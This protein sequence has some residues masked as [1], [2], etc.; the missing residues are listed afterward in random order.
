EFSKRMAQNY[1]LR[2]DISQK[3]F[4]IKFLNNFI[5]QL[6]PLF[7]YSIGGYLVITGSLSFGA[8]VAVLAAYKDLAS[9][10]RE[11]LD[12][13]QS[14]QDTEIKYE[15]IIEQFAP[16]GMISSERQLG[17]PEAKAAEGELAAV[18][19]SWIND[20]GIKIIDGVSLALKPASHIAIVGP[21]TGGKHELGMLLSGIA[22][23]T[24][25]Q[26]CLGGVDLTTLPRAMVARHVG[27][28]GQNTPLF[29]G[30]FFDN[31]VIGLQ[32]RPNADDPDDRDAVARRKVE[33]FEAELTGNSIDNIDADWIDYE[34]AGAS[35]REQLRERILECLRV[36]ELVG[37]LRE[38]GLRGQVDPQKRPEIADVMLKARGALREHLTAPEMRGY[39]EMFDEDRFNDQ[40]SIAENVLFGTPVGGGFDVERLAEH[41]YVQQV[42]DKLRLTDHWTEVGSQIAAQMVE[43]FSGLPPGHELLQRYSFISP[44]ELP[45]YSAALTRMHRQG[46]AGMKPEERARFLSLVFRVVPARHRF[47]VID[48]TL[49]DEVLQARRLFAQDLPAAMAPLVQFFDVDRYNGAVTLYDNMLFGR[50]APGQAQA[51]SRV[52]EMIVDALQRAGM[53][54]KVLNAVIDVGLDYQ[55]GIGGTRL[56][57]AMRQKLAVA[58]ALLKQP[59][60][61][62]LDDPLSVLETSAQGRVVDQV[63]A[64]SKDRSVLWTLQRTQFSKHFARVMVVVDGRIAEQGSFEELNRPATLLHKQLAAD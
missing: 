32:V 34:S 36:T 39:F 19:V 4:F 38:L 27:Y 62:I 55:V 10:W 56:S 51:G 2:V 12:Y 15:Q 47:D 57:A 42:L 58:R 54:E 43:I 8:L 37:D 60:I 30:S 49:R 6:T 13:Y 28:V 64:A 63:L 24:N 1:Y 21:E 48:E 53:A 18:G 26:V 14:M 45:E 50:L 17:A 40:A 31:L 20:A 9:P 16:P 59:A 23:P 33:L 46:L 29:A 44:T 3:K 7:V 41:P 11:L 22:D 25:G 5:S 35:T 52:R 61:L